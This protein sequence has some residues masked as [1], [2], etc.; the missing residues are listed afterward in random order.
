M[1]SRIKN[2]P[3]VF[4]FAYKNKIHRLQLTNNQL[5][6]PIPQDLI[7]KE[8]RDKLHQHLIIQPY[9]SVNELLGQKRQKVIFFKKCSWGLQT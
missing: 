7:L 3:G 5:K 6:L 9:K 8:K 1:L 2:K 4:Y